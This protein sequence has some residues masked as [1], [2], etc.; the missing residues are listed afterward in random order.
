MSSAATGPPP[1]S[2]WP[3]RSSPPGDQ[4]PP[5]APYYALPQPRTGATSARS[6][7]THRPAPAAANTP[8]SPRTNTD[9]QILMCW[10][11]I[12]SWKLALLRFSAA[13]RTFM[14]WA[15]STSSFSGHSL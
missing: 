5:G 10:K 15:S 13:M 9:T 3:R 6:P 1:T 8:P 11:S 14:V 12:C 2:R 7:P 4:P